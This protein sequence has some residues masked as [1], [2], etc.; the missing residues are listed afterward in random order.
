MPRRSREIELAD[1]DAVDQDAAALDVVEAQQQA[2]DRG[3]AGPGGADD[4][5]AL[6]GRDLERDV[7][8]DPVARRC[9]GEP[10]VLEDDVAARAGRPRAAAAA[11]EAIVTGV[12]SSV[13]MRS[14]EAI[15]AC[16]RLNFSDMS[17]IGRK[18]RCAY[19]RKATSA[20]SV[21]APDPTQPPPTTMISAAASVATTS[22]AG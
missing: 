10:H 12:S 15:A 21:S 2:D 18:K 20:P 6:A 5:D 9:V 7:A 8:E 3:L 11:G 1:V 4:A 13:K 17:L 16:S 22:I 14:D 19:C